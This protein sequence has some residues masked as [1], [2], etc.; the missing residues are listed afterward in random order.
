MVIG[1]G[2]CVGVKSLISGVLLSHAFSGELKA[3]SVVNEAIQDGVAEGWVADNVVP[4][5][6]GDLT[7]DD[8]GGATVG[9]AAFEV[10]RRPRRPS[11]SGEPE[12]R[13]VK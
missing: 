3:V 12:R 11:P 2:V 13:P 4:M 10:C 9:S 6:N 7:G 1:S 8:G 5:F